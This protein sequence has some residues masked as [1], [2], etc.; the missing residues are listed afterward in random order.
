MDL[1]DAVAWVGRDGADAAGERAR[2]L[3]AGHESTIDELARALVAHGRLNQAEILAI[4]DLH[5][6]TEKRAP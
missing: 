3:L 5:L 4:L 2:N 1:A 6:G